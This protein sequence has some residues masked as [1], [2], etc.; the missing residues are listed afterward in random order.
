LAVWRLTI[1]AGSTKRRLVIGLCPDA[2]QITIEARRHSRRGHHRHGLHALCNDV[3][4][5]LVTR[6]GEAILH[7]DLGS[8]FEHARTSCSKV[9][10][11]VVNGSSSLEHHHS[12]ASPSHSARISKLFLCCKLAIRLSFTLPRSLYEM[13]VNAGKQNHCGN[14]PMQA[15]DMVAEYRQTK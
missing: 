4:L 12:P 14:R 10:A 8:D 1:A 9:G 7:R 15:G 3:H 11:S 5:D 2:A 13:V 6:R